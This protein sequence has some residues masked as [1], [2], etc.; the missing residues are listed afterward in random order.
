MKR[1]I[2]MPLLIWSMV[3]PQGVVG[4]DNVST[5]PLA[6]DTRHVDIP[7]ISLGEGIGEESKTREGLPTFFGKVKAH[8][9]VTVAFIGGSITHGN[10]CYRLQLSKYLEQR[11][12]DSRF[13]WINAGVPGTGT[14]LGVFRIDNQVLEYNPDVVF[15]EFSVNGGYTPAMEGMIRKIRMRLPQTDICL[16][17]SATERYMRQYQQGSIPDV[18]VEEERL[19]EHYHLPSVHMAMVAAR[20]EAEGRLLW[21]GTEEQ[22]ASRILFSIDGLHPVTSGGNLYAAAVARAMEKFGK[23]SASAHQALPAPL[24]GTAWDDAK[25]FV[26]SEVCRRHGLWHDVNT[27]SDGRLKQFKSWFPTL[28]TSG[29][30]ESTLSFAFDGDMF[31]LFDLGGPEM[32]ELEIYV[33]GQMVRLKSVSDGSF[34]FYQ[35]TDLTGSHYLNRFNRHCNNRYRGQF[36]LIKVAP[37]IHQVTIKLSGHRVDKRK[38]LGDKQLDD[39]TANP[40]KYTK[41]YLRLGRILVRGNISECRPIKGLP[42]MKQQLKWEKKIRDYMSRDSMQAMLPDAT[43][44]LGSS[45]IDM[46]KTLESDFSGKNV[47]RRGIS[48]TKAIDI[49]NYRRLLVSPFNPRRIILYEGDN[50]IGYKWSV[51][52]IMDAMKKL[53]FEIRRMK[54]DAAIYIVSV[55]PSPVRTKSL[56]KIRQLNV[57]IQKFVK[58]QPNAGFIDIF[59]P[60]LDADGN[61]RSELFLTDGLHL[62]KD[63]YDIWRKEFGKVINR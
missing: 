38:I 60:M 1:W 36:D 49:Y 2:L 44:V 48:G 13:S 45:T 16:L 33:D 39:I 29:H 20:L 5:S 52:E 4:N 37:G 6:Y 42:K 32:G 23:G 26:P 47:I 53:F 27:G 63:G 34:R 35:A 17:Y 7:Q 24:Y 55:K 15:I 19:A 54:P 62:N 12:P 8:K 46:W 56:D 21:R 11:Y 3:S 57:E 25:M 9:P 40:D 61:V 31:G 10:F 18:V 22:A 58:N 50:E 51:D 14:E 30:P 59:T 41:T 43:L 28:M